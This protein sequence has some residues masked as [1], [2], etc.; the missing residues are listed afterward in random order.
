MLLT[1]YRSADPAGSGS[2]PRPAGATSQPEKNQRPKRKSKPQQIQQHRMGD[3]LQDVP[4]AVDVDARRP[5]P[6]ENASWLRAG[7]KEP[8]STVEADKETSR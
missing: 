2:A 7:G 4:D 5:E 3:D 1:I 8:G 6:D